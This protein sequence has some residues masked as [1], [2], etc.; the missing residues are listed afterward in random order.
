MTN[1]ELVATYTNLLIIQY[2]DPNNQPNA[3]ATIQMLA[4][5]AIA[6]QIVYQ[7]LNGFSPTDSYGQTPAVGVQLD[8]LGQ[9]VGAQRFLNGYSPSII[10]FGMQD[11]TGTYNSQAGGYGDATSSTPPTDYWLTTQGAAG[12]YTLSDTQMISLIQYLA[13]VNNAYLSLEVIDNI[14]YQFFGTYVTVTENPMEL[15]YNHA[16]ND[17][18][19][20]YGIVKFLN[21]LPHPAGVEVSAG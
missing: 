10:Y 1:D 12:S 6:N 4:Q 5:E 7:V 21:A 11:T 15:I 9:F 18:G 8:I 13:A 19:T 3:V 17:P 14:L 16:S 20:L 2:S